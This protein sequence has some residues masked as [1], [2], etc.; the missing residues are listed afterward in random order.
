MER[1]AERISDAEAD[2]RSGLLALLRDVVLPAL[3]P[4]ALAPFLPL[5]VAHVSAA[6][7]HLA[8]AVRC[9]EPCQFPL[10][11]PLHS[12]SSQIVIP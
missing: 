9:P 8:D 1:L 11:G 2:V 7:T 10:L 6:M 12:L 3:G 4:A 5:L